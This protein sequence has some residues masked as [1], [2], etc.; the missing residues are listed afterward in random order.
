MITI[1]Q[2][3][4]SKGERKSVEILPII[5]KPKHPKK[6]EGTQGTK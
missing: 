1:G 6:T 3:R 2:D 4:K 5:N